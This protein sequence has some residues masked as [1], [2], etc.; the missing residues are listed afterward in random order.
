[1]QMELVCG[2]FS[3]LVCV[4]NIQYSEMKWRGSK[5][6]HWN[7]ST[8]HCQL[9]LTSLGN[10]R[11]HSTSPPPAH[12]LQARMWITN[13]TLLWRLSDKSS[14]T[15]SISLGLVICILWVSYQMSLI[16]ILRKFRFLIH[17]KRGTRG[18]FRLVIKSVRRVGIAQSVRAGRSGDRIPVGGEIL[19]I[20]RDRPW[21][22]PNPLYNGYRG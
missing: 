8:L 15:P 17:S 3:P 10:L 16:R 11:H 20:C 2:A 21:G 13:W 7:F 9:L 14:R 22:P 12:P 18:K 6:K 1:M 4:C 19:R 5:K